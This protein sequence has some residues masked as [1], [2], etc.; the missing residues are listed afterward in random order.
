MVNLLKGRFPSSREVDRWIYDL[1]TFVESTVK[2]FPAPLEVNRMFYYYTMRYL[3]RRSRFVSGP[4]RG[5]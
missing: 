2:Q 3:L 1:D 5:G 4:S